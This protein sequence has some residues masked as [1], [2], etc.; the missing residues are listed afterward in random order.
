M[1]LVVVIAVVVA[2]VVVLRKAKTNK[3]YEVSGRGMKDVTS[4]VN[5]VTHTS[6][7]TYSQQAK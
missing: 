5:G 1:V 2:V 4:D 3:Q 7:V 6:T